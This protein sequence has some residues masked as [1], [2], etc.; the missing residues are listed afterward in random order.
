M[1]RRRFKQTA[2][3]NERLTDDAQR[4]RKEAR[5]TPAGIERERLIRKARQAEAATH[6]QAWLSSSGLQPPK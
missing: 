6:I 2:S 4:S 5:G 3:L 1:L